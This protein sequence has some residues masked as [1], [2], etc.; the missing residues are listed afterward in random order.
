MVHKNEHVPDNLGFITPTVITVLELFMGEPMQQFHEREVVRRTKVSKGSA[1]RILRMLAGMGMLRSE[2]KGRMVF[3]GLDLHDPVA[4]QFK[5]LQ[6]V[7]S[8]RT[9]TSKIRNHAKKAILFGSRA[10]G[11]DAQSSDT[12]VLVL[13]DEKD[14]VRKIISG[15]NRQAGRRIA[16]IVVDSNEFIRLKREDKALYDSIERGIMLWQA[17]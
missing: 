5:V 15:F 9:L 10:Q 7:Y 8:L 3:Y 11:T 12:D 2:R 13:T 16:P 14:F 6:N 4:R 17:E 1:N